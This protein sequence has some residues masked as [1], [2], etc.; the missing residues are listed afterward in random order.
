MK[1]VCTISY[2]ALLTKLHGKL[3]DIIITQAFAPISNSTEE[4]IDL[5]YKKQDL[6]LAMCK[7]F[8]LTMTQGDLYAKVGNEKVSVKI[9]GYGL[10]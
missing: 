9:V 2:I 5:L 4:N 6:T 10:G 8:K 3:L 1:G 7:D